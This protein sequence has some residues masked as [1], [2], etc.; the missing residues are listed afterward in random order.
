[1]YEAGYTRKRPRGKPPLSPS[2]ER[3]RYAWALAHNP[4]KYEYG[5][6]LGYDFRVVCFTN[7]TLARVGEQRGMQR[8][9]ARNNEVYYVDVRKDRNKKDCCL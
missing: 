5:D 9:W 6:G 8:A 1:M 4:D 3:E 7:K 2:Q